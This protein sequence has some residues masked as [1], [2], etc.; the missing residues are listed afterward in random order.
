MKNILLL[1]L[2][3]ALF[4]QANAQHHHHR[5]GNN[6]GNY[7]N[8]R[9]VTHRAPIQ[10]RI[11]VGIPVRR[12]PVCIAP[13]TRVVYSNCNICHHNN[14]CNH[15][16]G[17]RNGYNNQYE[18]LIYQLRNTS[19][20]SDKLIVAKQAVR[21]QGYNADQIAG[22]M[23]EFSYES[24]RLEFAKFSYGFCVDPHNYYQVNSA[25]QYSS[26]ISEL[27]SFIH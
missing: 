5:G 9:I 19:F 6:H 2:A 10:V 21:G 1:G 22:I 14:G 7:R 24:S 27:E 11:N 15:N 20:E 13:K 16:N 8:K 26:S 3:V 25:F 12:N 4:G 17:V 18:D 23:M